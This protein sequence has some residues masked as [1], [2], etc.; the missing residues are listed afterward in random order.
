MPGEVE[1]NNAILDHC[2]RSDEPVKPGRRTDMSQKLLRDLYVCRHL[3]AN[4]TSWLLHRW[5]V[6]SVRATMSDLPSR[7]AVLPAEI[8]VLE[9][10]LLIALLKKKGGIRDS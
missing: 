2:N 5:I 7:S 6:V 1:L 8:E 4:V 3:A 10:G 9:L